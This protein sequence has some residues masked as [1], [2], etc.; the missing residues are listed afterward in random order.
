ML[1]SKQQTLVPN[2]VKMEQEAVSPDRAGAGSPLI[3]VCDSPESSVSSPRSP[4][5]TSFH[6]SSGSTIASPPPSLPITN[7]FLFRPFLNMPLPLLPSLPLGP[8]PSPLTS[9]PLAFSIDSILSSSRSNIQEDIKPNLHQLPIP[10]PI[11]RPVPIPPPSQPSPAP[12]KTSPVSKSSAATKSSPPKPKIDVEVPVDFSKTSN[13]APKTDEDCPPGM[14]R[15]PNGQLWPAWVFCTRYS[16]RPSSGPRVRKVKKKEPGAG[17]APVTATRGG[18]EDEKRPRTA[19]S[20]EQLQK[21]RHE[22]QANRYLTEERRRHLSRELGLNEN[23]I[24]IWFQNKRAKLKKSAGEKGELAKMLDA[25]GLYNHQTVPL[26][27][28]EEMAGI[29]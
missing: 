25:Q 16:D 21:L 2:T 7:P 24:K 23:Q 28:E 22:F 26:D 29:F 19:F 14:V 4:L 9:K 13:E 6:S 17:P 3:R 8:H 20:S 1:V 15:G 18:A 10:R 11:P 5:S 27:E 12:P